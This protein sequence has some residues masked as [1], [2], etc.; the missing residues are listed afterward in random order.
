[1]AHRQRVKKLIGDHDQR[2]LR[3]IVEPKSPRDRNAAI[4]QRLLLA[5]A[6][7]RA[8]LDHGH[9]DSRQKLRR[10]AAG[11]QSVRH[12]SSAPRPQLH[13]LHALGVIHR[14]PDMGG[15][16][17]D[18]LAKHLRN[19]GRGD[20]I[21]IGAERV[22][23]DVIPMFGVS[24]TQF[25]EPVERHRPFGVDDDADLV[26]QFRQ[27]FVSSA[28]RLRARNTSAIPSAIS[29]SDS[30]MPMVAPP[31]RNPNCGSGSRKNSAAIRATP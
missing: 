20:K 5:L 2:A 10:D 27:T 29:G 22:A 15:P 3:N 7:D 21:S 30:N 31:N 19:L 8:G 28:G 14:A 24:E 12:Q 11:A 4:G 25:H 17:S 13:E 1:M 23:G 18:Q 6:Q 9:F 26:G 16:E